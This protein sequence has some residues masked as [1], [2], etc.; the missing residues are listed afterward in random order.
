MNMEL[1]QEK[2]VIELTKNEIQEL[3]WALYDSKIKSRE[4]EGSDR[5][6][7][8]KLKVLLWGTKRLS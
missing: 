1:D 8:S 6:R 4:R 5:R 3:L 2:I 7:R